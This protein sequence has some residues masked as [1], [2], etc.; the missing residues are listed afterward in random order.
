MQQMIQI[1]HGH[2]EYVPPNYLLHRILRMLNKILP[3]LN[4]WRRGDAYRFR[5]VLVAARRQRQPKSRQHDDGG[6]TS[7]RRASSNFSGAKKVVDPWFIKLLNIKLI[8]KLVV[9]INWFNDNGCNDHTRAGRRL[10]RVTKAGSLVW[11]GLVIPDHW[12]WTRIKWLKIYNLAQ[13]QK[14][15]RVEQGHHSFPSWN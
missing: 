4:R 13:V 10:R 7:G 3:K 6:G 1:K 15:H 5:R 8:N 11:I 14:Q 9:C 12:T 2:K